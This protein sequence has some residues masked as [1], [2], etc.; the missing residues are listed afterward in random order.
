MIMPILFVPGM[1]IFV[2]KGEFWI[3]KN[4]EDI[5][6]NEVP[7]AVFPSQFMQS[8]KDCFINNSKIVKDNDSARDYDLHAKI[9]VEIDGVSRVL[10]VNEG[11]HRTDPDI[12]H[13]EMA[14]LCLKAFYLVN[15]VWVQ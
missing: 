8:I 4:A 12:G 15:C 9:K 10:A 6:I 14:D 13:L 5:T 1:Q 2:F 7:H 3:K 11:N